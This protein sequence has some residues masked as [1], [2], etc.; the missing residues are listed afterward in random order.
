LLHWKQ[1]R[2]KNRDRLNSLRKLSRQQPARAQYEKDSAR[3]RKG[4]FVGDYSRAT[5]LETYGAICHLCN[6]T[7]DL[8]APKQVGKTGWEVGFHIDHVI[9]ISKG[10]ADNLA[11]VR[12]AHAYCN[13]RKG[14]KC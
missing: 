13:Q 4:A 14:R 8:E 11:N 7:I 9:P 5:V 12:P 6:L 2:E 3:R 1:R 10:G